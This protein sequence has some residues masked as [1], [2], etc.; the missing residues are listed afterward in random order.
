MTKRQRGDK[1]DP[2]TG[3]GPGV[4]DKS[5]RK[6]DDMDKRSPGGGEQKP[7]SKAIDISAN[8]TNNNRVS[9][10]MLTMYG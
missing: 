9:R 1:R 4:G 7:V 2:T 10:V 5:G 6:G 3:S 8:S